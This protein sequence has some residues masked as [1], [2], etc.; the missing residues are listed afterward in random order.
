LAKICSGDFDCE[1]L[2]G[3]FLA[4]L[5]MTSRF[6]QNLYKSM[7]ASNTKFT[8][9]VPK[10]ARRNQPKIEIHDAE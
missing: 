4:S 8:V 9:L 10:W 7:C 2:A 5:S 3:G 6:M 1:L